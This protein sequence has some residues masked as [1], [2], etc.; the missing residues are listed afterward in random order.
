VAGGTGVVPFGI[1]DDCI[2]DAEFGETYTIK[3]NADPD[4]S[5]ELCSQY[6]GN[7]GLLGIDTG[8]AGS[9]C[10]DPPDTLEELK[11]KEAICFGSS[12][13][14][15]AQGATDCEGEYDDENCGFF[16]VPTDEESCTETGN[17]SAIK[18]AINWRLDNT[19]EDCDTWEE[20]TFEGGGL[21]PACN[22]WLNDESKRVIMIPV[23]DGLFEGSPGLKKIDLVRFAVFFLEGLAD[24]SGGPSSGNCEVTGR[25]VTTT[26]TASYEGLTDLEEDSSLTVVTLVN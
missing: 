4:A 23:V 3:Y 9:G 20:V 17:V 10:G 2:A 18:E 5:D 7:F 12:R 14:L 11:L 6:G 13:F 25:F 24:C 1:E 15:C 16:G 22:P 8:G 19:S 21:T 26:M